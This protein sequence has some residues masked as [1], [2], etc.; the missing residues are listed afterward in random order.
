[1]T[2]FAH[3]T[4]RRSGYT[5]TKHLSPER[6]FMVWPWTRDA[7]GSTRQEGLISEL[8]RGSPRPERTP[9]STKSMGLP[10]PVVSESRTTKSSF[11]RRERAHPQRAEVRLP[12]ALALYPA[13]LATVQKLAGHSD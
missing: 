9:T 12:A 13:D 5:S 6:H 7:L 11:K 1:M 8:K 2:R 4:S 10:R 3:I